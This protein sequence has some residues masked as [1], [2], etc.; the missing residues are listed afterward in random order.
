MLD[1]GAGTTVRLG[2][3]QLLVATGG[4]PIRPD[5]PGIDLPFI[6][7][8]QTLEDAEVLLSLAEQGCRRVVVVGGGYIGLELAESFI[9]RG[10]TATIVERQAPAARDARRRLRPTRRRRPRGVTASTSA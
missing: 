3:D 6:R 5:L 9:E 1:E 7:G 8:V 10:C 2:Y 4:A